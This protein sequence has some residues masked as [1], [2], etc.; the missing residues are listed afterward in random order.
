MA[1]DRRGAGRAAV[2]RAGRWRAFAWMAVALAA[3]G[4]ASTARPPIGGAG[5]G[6]AAAGAP[7]TD[8][9]GGAGERR[10]YRIAYQG[11][12]GSGSLRLALFVVTPGR[13][14]ARAS[15]TFGRA[16]WGLELAGGGAV[17]IDHRRR[18]LCIG[19]DELRIPELALATLPLDRLPE[20]LAGTLPSSPA[21]AGA[22][23][24]DFVDAGGRRWTS[25]SADG[26][27]GLD[28]W[29]LWEEERPLLWWS[30]RDS[31]GVLSHRDGAQFRWR[32]TVAESLASPPPA[33]AVP[34]GYRQIACSELT[35]AAD[36]G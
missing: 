23:P 3:M 32:R 26:G 10:L 17:F 6:E 33:L 9:G 25:R 28:A 11:P 18:E 34:D 36:D 13:Y 14:Q 2:R 12:E 31:G 15:D 24:T 21:R 16:L 8:G 19:R 7:Q 4:C 27:G 35:L 20:L 30:R 29:T 22:D 1:T 5:A